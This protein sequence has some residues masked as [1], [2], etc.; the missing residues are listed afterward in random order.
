MGIVAREFGRGYPEA[1]DFDGATDEITWSAFTDFA[2]SAKTWAAWIK[3]D[4]APSS[5]EWL[6]TFQQTGDTALSAYVLLRTDLTLKFFVD[7]DT[8]DL[9]V[10]SST[11]IPTGQWVHIL[12]HEPASNDTAADVHIYIDGVEVSYSIQ[13]DGS[14]TRVAWAGIWVQGG[15]ASSDAN[16]FTGDMAGPGFWDVELS[17]GDRALAVAG[18]SPT[19][20]DIANVQWAPCFSD[21]EDY[22]SGKTATFDG[23]S[24]DVAPVQLAPERRDQT[25]LDFTNP[26]FEP[27]F[28]VTPMT[29]IASIDWDGAAV[30]TLPR[31]LEVRTSG[32]AARMFLVLDNATSSAAFLFLRTT[33]SFFAAI[34]FAK[35]SGARRLAVTYNGGTT[36]A[37]DVE[38]FVDGIAVALAASTDGSGAALS[39]ADG[40]FKFGGIGT[41][42]MDGLM[43]EPCVYARV[44]S[45]DE[46]TADADGNPSPDFVLGPNL[47]TLIDAPS[48][49]TGVAVGT[50]ITPLLIAERIADDV[51]EAFPTIRLLNFVNEMLDRLL[52][53]DRAGPIFKALHRIFVERSEDLITLARKVRDSF[54]IEKA[55]GAQLDILGALLQRPRLEAET[56]DRYRV[57]LQIQI[58]LILSSAGNVDTILSVV[59]KFTGEPALS[60][61]ENYPASFMID[62]LVANGEAATLADLV[63]RARIL[64]VQG[65]VFAAGALD[66]NPFILD[67]AGPAGPIANAGIL[68]SVGV[69][70]IFEPAILG[71]IITA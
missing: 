52:Q 50:I 64:G 17:S 27:E 32:G 28:G 22:I 38:F 54:W 39:A 67:S 46:I 70:A 37:T 53:V 47:R 26:S 4:A 34:P 51:A 24:L 36:A 14:G 31:I 55:V 10:T 35:S 42:D 29:V 62:V 68:D 56:D 40:D 33:T 9:N 2:T 69:V 6:H 59:E 43:L 57:I 11:V 20:I 65:N 66:E 25:R 49:Q 61:I 15:R 18:K 7:Y 44:L 19:F 48:S 8:T 1:R 60:Y 12:V 23:T 41:E 21:G 71:R 16:Q 30:G 63:R 5:T 13:T 58:D 3:V 45:D